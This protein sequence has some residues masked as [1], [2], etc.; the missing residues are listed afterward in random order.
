MRELFFCEILEPPAEQTHMGTMGDC[1]GH[2]QAL[3]GIDAIEGLFVTGS[4]KQ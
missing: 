3:M 4:T 1:G 2:L